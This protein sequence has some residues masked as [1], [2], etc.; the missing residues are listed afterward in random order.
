MAYNDPILTESTLGRVKILLK[1][2]SNEE[3]YELNGCI[4]GLRTSENHI[5]ESSDR[6]ELMNKIEALQLFFKDKWNS[7]KKEQNLHPGSELSDKLFH[8][9]ESLDDEIQKLITLL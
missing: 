5:S 9:S 7:Y 3:A 2:Y 8:E 1:Q 4:G 6:L